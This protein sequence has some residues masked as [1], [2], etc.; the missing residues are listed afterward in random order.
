MLLPEAKKLTAQHTEQHTQHTL[1]PLLEAE[2]QLQARLSSA[3][4]LLMI[5]FHS[6]LKKTA[7]FS[8][9]CHKA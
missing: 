5:R 3:S 6:F 1:N 7:E 4:E 2:A 8:I 9:L